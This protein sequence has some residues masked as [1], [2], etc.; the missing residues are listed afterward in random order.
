VDTA[1]LRA[2][3]SHRQG[4]DGSLAGASAAAV[5]AR[6]G[7]ARSVAGAGPYLTFHAR[8]GL[9]RAAVDAAVA[10]LLVHELPAARGCTYVVPAEDFALALRAGRGFASAG[11]MRAA[12]KLGVTPKEI[13]ALAA[14]VVQAVAKGPL[15]PEAIRDAVGDAARSLGEA[16]KKKGLT[17]TLPLA[18]GKLQEVGAIRRVPVNGRLDQQ[19][20][21]Y[22]PWRPG[23]LDGDRR[24]DDEI[25]AALAAKYFRWTGPATLAEFQWFSGLGVK[26][27]QAAV[28]GLGLVPLPGDAARLM[29]PDD[30]DA[31]SAFAP[32]R[33][34]Q[35]LFVGSLDALVLLRRD[36]ASLL[37]E[38]DRAAEVVADKATERVGG[39][40][41]LP[42]HAIVDRGRVI[43]L[44]EYDTETQSIAWRTLGAVPKTVGAAIVRAAAATEAF[45][46][47]DLGDARSFSLDSPKS[48]APRIA[49]IR[50]HR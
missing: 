45:V 24:T 49:A 25:R 41:D 42:S 20:Y 23:P 36:L 38:K 28:A 30:L 29:F 40:T 26:A 1:R 43:G 37:D 11:D 44:W 18:L 12:E 13:D 32:P 27:A 31:L 10:A 50:A 21:R 48:R 39:L 8:A 34:P 5:L 3:W 33:A 6:S 14:K 35:P 16:G 46:R 7:W 22:A 2:W 17:T 15:D 4:L 9:G 19:R 47:D